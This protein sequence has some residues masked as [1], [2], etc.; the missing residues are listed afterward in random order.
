MAKSEE[1]KITTKTKY[2]REIDLDRRRKKYTSF[3]T[4][5]CFSYLTRQEGVV[6]PKKT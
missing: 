4:A 2:S 5:T 3:V 1:F 6:R